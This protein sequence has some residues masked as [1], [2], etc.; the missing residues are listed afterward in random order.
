MFILLGCIQKQLNEGKK[1]YVAFVDFKKAFNMVNRD[2]LF[3]KLIKSGLH[4]KV[5]NVLRSLYNQTKARA[6]INGV[7]YDW[8][9]D[10]VGMNQGGPNSPNLF[11]KFLADLRDYLDC[12]YGVVLNSE[13]ILLHLLWA[14]DL[15]LLCDTEKGL[16]RQLNG[17]FMFCKDCHMIVNETKTKVVLYGNITPEDVKLSFNGKLL[18]I[19]SQYKYL[20]ILFNSIKHVRGNVFREACESIG[21]KA[22]R[23]MFK[24][25]KDMKCVGTTPPSVTLKLFDSLVLPI[26]EY[27]SEIVFCGKEI[28]PLERIHVKQLKYMFGVYNNA[29]HLAIYGETG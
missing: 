17:L 18:E 12:N 9:E 20:G 13:T 5:N 11:R 3:M 26:L 25:K 28:V 29:S 24:I 22:T 23:A 14:D 7:L 1:L 10:Q 19:V 4:G 2:T 15:V 8:I 27:G 16:Q 6:K 21:T